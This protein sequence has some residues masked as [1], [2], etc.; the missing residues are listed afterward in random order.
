MIQ[1]IHHVAHIFFPGRSADIT[2][3][4]IGITT[5]EAVFFSCFLQLTAK[6]GR[7]INAWLYF[8][9]IT[10][11]AVG[12]DHRVAIGSFPQAYIEGNT[13]GRAPLQLLRRKTF[14]TAMGPHR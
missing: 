8:S 4:I 7:G 6:E 11:D 14:D 9:T 10:A 1:R 5:I 2:Y 3:S 13:H 12:H